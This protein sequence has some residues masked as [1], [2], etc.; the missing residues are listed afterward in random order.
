MEERG[1]QVELAVFDLCLSW[2][3]SGDSDGVGGEPV[4]TARTGDLLL[5]PASL[6]AKVRWYDRVVS[7]KTWPGEITT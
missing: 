1:I 6:P 7:L 5:H 4:K 2:H 3:A